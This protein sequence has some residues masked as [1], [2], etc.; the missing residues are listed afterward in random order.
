MLLDDL[1]LNGTTC[2]DN[3]E[4]DVLVYNLEGAHFSKSTSML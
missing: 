4:I 3:T 1:V 2:R